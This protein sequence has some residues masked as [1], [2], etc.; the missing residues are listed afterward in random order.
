MNG[1][2]QSSRGMPGPDS[3]GEDPDLAGAG[4][5]AVENSRQRSHRGEERHTYLLEGQGAKRG[6]DTG[7]SGRGLGWAIEVKEEQ[8]A[9]GRFD[10]LPAPF[11]LCCAFF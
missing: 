7:R 6:R 4:L 5:R 11:K 9:G 10:C 8:R 2:A 1:I 3:A